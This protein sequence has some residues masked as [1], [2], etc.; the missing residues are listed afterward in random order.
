M[1]DISSLSNSNAGD[2][3]SSLFGEW[4]SAISALID[5]L[6]PYLAEVGETGTHVLGTRWKAGIDRLSGAENT[7]GA[8]SPNAQGLASF[9]NSAD[10]F[11]NLTRELEESADTLLN[12]N[13]QNAVAVGLSRTYSDKIRTLAAATTA[14]L[15]RV[16]E[17]RDRVLASVSGNLWPSLSAG[18]ISEIYSAKTRGNI[19]TEAY[20]SVL[21]CLRTPESLRLL[22]DAKS[23]ALGQKPDTVDAATADTEALSKFHPCQA[24]GYVPVYRSDGAITDDLT[25]PQARL[26]V[27]YDL[28]P[29]V[30]RKRAIEWGPI[31]ATTSGLNYRLVERLRTIRATPISVNTGRSTPSAAGVEGPVRL[32]EVTG[33]QWFPLAGPRPY[34][35]A[36]ADTTAEII[37]DRLK[38]ASSLVTQY[39]TAIENETIP[40]GETSADVLVDA[41]VT[42][43][44]LVYD[45]ATV[46]DAEAFRAL[47]VTE[48]P[49]ADSYIGRA[50]ARITGEQLSLRLRAALVHPDPGVPYAAVEREARISQAITTVDITRTVWRRIE[51]TTK[52]RSQI[53][54]LAPIR[55]RS[56]LRHFKKVAIKAA[57]SVLCMVERLHLKLFAAGAVA[58]LVSP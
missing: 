39:E 4:K 18:A 29:L 17:C 53:F 21:L 28:G 5:S 14:A 24:M 25:L 57:E 6:K 30:D 27:V 20:V 37:L 47:V 35:S 3:S 15:L 48:T 10:Q 54:T 2:N 36:Y 40:Y 8:I 11:E 45:E 22:E 55:R 34:V 23:S 43:F 16:R 13:V 33:S 26:S 12:P 41:L 50:V 44:T 31:A 9:M 42:A 58:T 1:N 49:M 46:A 7:L 19:A 52:C 32:G 51:T 56:L 38:G